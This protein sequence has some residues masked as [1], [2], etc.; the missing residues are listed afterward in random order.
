MYSQFLTT[1]DRDRAITWHIV[2]LF[3]LLLPG[4][5]GLMET[6]GKARLGLLTGIALFWFVG[7]R[8]AARS[9]LLGTALNWGAI[10]VGLCQAFLMGHLFVGMWAVSI[11]MQFEVVQY[12]YGY[13]TSF[14]GG[15]SATCIMGACLMLA[16]FSMG[17]VVLA[18]SGL[19]TREPVPPRNA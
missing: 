19:A 11:G 5:L 7:W 6:E 16:C 2:Y 9:S 15:L 18:L 8:I 13:L 12:E 14:L 4:L 1:S 10:F 3:N 17:F